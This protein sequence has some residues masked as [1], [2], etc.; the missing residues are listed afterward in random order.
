MKPFAVIFQLLLILKIL[1]SPPNQSLVWLPWEQF[2]KNV[3]CDLIEFTP[4]SNNLVDV[5]G[6][7]HPPPS[8]QCDGPQPTVMRC[9]QIC[10]LPTLRLQSAYIERAYILPTLRLQ[11][12]QVCLYNLRCALICL[13]ICLPCTF[14]FFC[15]PSA[16]H[17]LHTAVFLQICLPPKMPILPILIC[18][19]IYLLPTLHL[20]SAY[21]E[22]AYILLTLRLQSAQVCLYNLRC[23]LISLQICL[24]PTFPCSAISAEHNL[25]AVVFLQICLP[26]KMPILPKLIC[27]QIWLLP[28]LRLQSAY[29]ALSTPAYI[30]PTICLHCAFNACLH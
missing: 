17:N 30:K 20:Q 5:L 21:I 23:G 15:L 25:H 6:Q 1:D 26:P 13:Q 8:L 24:P 16:E 12:A 14:L 18:L 11:S 22:R 19:Q 3:D 10:L 29:I 4:P 27:L 2:L 28:T 9:L 7:Y